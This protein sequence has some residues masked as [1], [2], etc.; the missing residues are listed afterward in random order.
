M[1]MDIVI[2]IGFL[3]LLAYLTSLNFTD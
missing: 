2:G 1:E 3:L